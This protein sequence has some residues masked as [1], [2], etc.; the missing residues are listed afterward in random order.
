MLDRDF[1]TEILDTLSSNML[2]TVLTAFG[3]SWGVFMLSIMLGGANGLQNGVYTQFEG[4]AMN[5][6][7][8]WTQRTTMPYDGLP[9]GRRYRM[10]LGDYEAI[11]SSVD[12]IGVIAP[13]LNLGG[14]NGSS[15][16]VR[17]GEERNFGIF[18]DFPQIRQVDF[19]EMDEGRFINTLDIEEVRKVAVIGR[20]V[21]TELYAP[22]EEAIGSYIKI[23]GVPFRV[24][25]VFKS[26]FSGERAKNEEERVHVPF[27]VCKQAFN[28]GDEVGWMALT[29]KPNIP[30]TQVG[31]EVKGIIRQR[32]RIHPDDRR[33]VG[34]WNMEEE[35]QEVQ[36]LFMG[37]QLLVW[38]V[39]I[40]TLLVGIVGV[41]NIML[42][43]IKERT[44]EFGVRRALGAKPLSIV[45]MVVAEAFILTLAAG[46]VGMVMGVLAVEG[47]NIASQG[48]GDNDMFANPGIRL[49]VPLR[50]IAILAIAGTLAGLLPALRAVSIKPVDA[51]RGA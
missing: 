23:N 45:G 16:V 33:A 51:L 27:T 42:I 47:M 37:I 10:N 38:I 22:Q 46:M 18:G 24:V 31:E 14:Y 11:K 13:R 36:S 35:F 34:S 50:A 1:W 4:R 26:G 20:Q 28:T 6:M 32:H 29:S 2:L 19:F 25:G 15:K 41:A 48:L 7:S 43:V 21:K 12:H 17:G 49:L 5:S 40:G 39:G 30:V 8:M 3:V 9:P 44:R